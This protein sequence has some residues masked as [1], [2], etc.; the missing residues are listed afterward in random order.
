VHDADKC[1]AELGKLVRDLIDV[2]CL[3][4][5]LVDSA[6]A[7]L[8]VSALRPLS[9]TQLQ[10]VRQV[11]AEHVGGDD[12]LGDAEDA[13]RPPL[14]ELVDE[15][16][17]DEGFAA[18]CSFPLRVHL[19]CLGSFSAFFD[20]SEALSPEVEEHVRL[21]A[22]EF[23][24]VAGLRVLYQENER[25][26]VSDGLTGVYNV[27]HL[28]QRLAEAFDH[29][30][31][32]RRPFSVMMLDVDHFK[33]IN[34]QHGHPAGDVVLQGVAQLLRQ[35]VRRGDVLGRY[36]GDEFCLVLPETKCEGASQLGERLRVAI[37]HAPFGDRDAPLRVTSSI[38]VAEVA[39]GHGDGSAVLADAD[40]ALYQSKLAGRNK[41]TVFGGSS[42]TTAT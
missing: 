11:A 38:G 14:R 18:Q 4:V 3:S 37:E 39:D 42:R 41:L 15:Q 2:S 1:C 34:D 27:R 33:Q 5:H 6:G 9:I 12:R 13:I 16:L 32:Y 10:L 36:G 30:Q 26:S 22:L 7:Q 25:L 8:H 40:T 31:R 28:R 35:S 19:D 20:R 24:P 21:L 29:H 17:T 23:T